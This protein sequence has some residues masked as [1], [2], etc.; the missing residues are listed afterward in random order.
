MIL[1]NSYFHG[2]EPLRK[3]KRIDPQV[4]RERAEKKVKRIQRDIRRLEKV[5]RKFKPI[6]E[7]EIPKKAIRDSERMRPLP[8]L[9]EE[10]IHERMELKQLWAVYKRKE[11][12]AEMSAIQRIIDAQEKALDAL[13][14]ASPSLYEA[15]IQPNPSF[16]PFKML[17]PV[18]TPPINKFDYPDG[19]Y[20]D[21]TKVYEP[22]LPTD[23]K[24]LRQLGLH[25]KKL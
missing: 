14:E 6:S 16:I 22:I 15:A 23:P 18:E 7:L 4:L 12:V 8:V 1:F 17:G 13:Q 19:N 2:A 10:E 3:K 21:I 5:A 9:S 20:T 24:K 11:H 25:K